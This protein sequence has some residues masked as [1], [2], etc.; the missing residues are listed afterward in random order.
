MKEIAENLTKDIFDYF[1]QEFIFGLVTKSQIA[2]EFNFEPDDLIKLKFRSKKEFLDILNEYKTDLFNRMNFEELKKCL[3]F[4]LEENGIDSKTKIINDKK[5]ENNKINQKEESPFENEKALDNDI[6]VNT[7]FEKGNNENFGENY[8]EK[9][10]NLNNEE[11]YELQD[12]EDDSDY[13][14]VYNTKNIVI[15]YDNTEKRLQE[16]NKLLYQL[17][18]PPS[19]TDDMEEDS[20]E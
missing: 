16:T 2:T 1:N 19:T 9:D 12:D 20:L 10:Y 5:V 15:K 11:E 8:K 4:K 6:N 17:K 14:P 13:L 7:K 18:V 3:L